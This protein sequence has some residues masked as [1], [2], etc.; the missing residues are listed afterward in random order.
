[1][2]YRNRARLATTAGIAATIAVFL[3]SGAAVAAPIAETATEP[4]VTQATTAEHPLGNLADTPP[5]GWSSWNTFGCDISA[6][7]IMQT[8][9]AMVA[10]GMKDAGY[11]YVNIDDCWSTKE[12]DADGKLVPDPVKFPDGIKGLADYVHSKGLKLG[13]YSSAGSH[14]CQG[15]PAGLYHEESDAQQYAEW[16]VDLLKYDNCGEKDDIPEQERY[17]RMHDALKATGR[18]IVFSLC[19][20]GWGKDHLW[21]GTEQIGHYFRVWGD[22]YTGWN[23]VME[24]ADVMA[25]MAP[26]SGPNNWADPDMLIAGVTE[27]LWWYPEDAHILSEAESASHLGLWAI[28]NSPL[29]AGNDLRNTPTWATEQLTNPRMLAIDQDWSGQI[30]T[31]VRQADD[32]EVWTK[33]MSDGSKAVLLLNRGTEPLSIAAT[34]DE[35]GLDA[36]TLA[37]QEV[38]SGDTF[39][40]QGEVR[41][42][43]GGHESAFYIVKAGAPEGA[44]SLT[45]FETDAPRNAAMGEPVDVNVNV[46][47]DGLSALTDVELSLTV[48]AGVTAAGPTTATIPTIAP[49][50]TGTL[51]VSLDPG[52][53]ASGT[54]IVVE[55]TAAW[56]AEGG[57]TEDSDSA[58]I[59]F[60]P[61]PA[62]GT[63]R[64]SSLEWATTPTNAWGP[65]EKDMSN[66]ESA[67]GDG[68]PLTIGG[69]V[70]EHGLGT[71]ANSRIEY[72]LD[73]RCTSLTA[74]VGIDD[75]I[76]N[77]I[78]GVE[79]VVYGDGVELARI[80]A[81]IDDG[82]KPLDVDL[83]GVGSL[84]LFADNLGNSHSD[85]ADWA[86]AEVVCGDAGDTDLAIDTIAQ[87]RCLGQKAVLVVRAT[88]AEAGPVSLTVRSAYGEKSFES[89]AAGRNAL[90]SFTTRV[91]PLP[92][93]TVTV[94]ATRLSD[95]ETETSTVSYDARDCA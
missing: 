71:N 77:P 78:A 41:A 46:H 25:G 31:R 82:P 9:D 72:F 69:T 61:A 42:R 2:R 4:V 27:M 52:S 80:P 13:I 23:S 45:M 39:S 62:A 57:R 33:N 29:I 17:Q 8:A 54:E 95:G 38:W 10:N 11:E 89:V 28:T 91:D 86:A 81:G 66:G 64:L 20:W 35:I 90:A 36:D 37:V 65:V 30:G 44:P 84:V 15:Y 51:A 3:G 21:N 50:E 56:G 19:D 83:T 68:R 74:Q 34:P 93:G 12:R 49:G 48:P 32:A 40:S 55:T 60:L 59:T 67:A 75:E 88:N 43:L 16:E 76:T 24:I 92:A 79:F 85:H 1:M 94:E 53:L 87:A 73:G 63:H 26:Y 14:T 70:Y 5:M 58:K 18:D 6:E 47:N 22:I 7:L